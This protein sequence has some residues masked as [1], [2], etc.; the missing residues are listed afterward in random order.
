MGVTAHRFSSLYGAGNRVQPTRSHPFQVSST[1][2]HDPVAPLL[3]RLAL[4]LGAAKFAGW[5]AVRSRQPAVLGEIL[6]GIV[7]GNLGLVGFHAL[8]P[9]A[10]DH[11]VDVLA[12]LGIIVL[13]FE[14]GLQSTVQEMLNVGASSTLVA[15][16]GVATPLVLGWAVG[17]YF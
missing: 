15:I 16:L 14:V 7:L 9:I 4:L 2:M 10:T 13:M 11:F 1:P 3:I 6:I 17:A 5:V 12:S 8:E